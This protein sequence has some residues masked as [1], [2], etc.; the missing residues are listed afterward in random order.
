MSSIRQI[1]EGP[2]VVEYDGFLYYTEG[3][4]T[5]APDLKLREMNSSYFGPGDQRVT[6]KMFAVEF[7]PVGMMDDNKDKYYPYTIADLGKLIAPSTDKAVIIWAASGQKIT[8]PAGV[9]T[10]S[11]QLLFGVDQGPMGSMTI[12]CL[13]DITKA[14]AAADAHYKIETAALETHTLDWDKAP[15]PAYKLTLSTAGDIDGLTGFTFD[16]GATFTPRSCNRYGTVNYKLSALAPVITFAPAYQSESAMFNLLNIQGAGAAKLGG[17]HKLGQ[18]LTLL[19]AEA[20]AKGIQIDYPDCVI[21]S[22][23][24][25]FSRDDPRHGDYAII[26]AHVTGSS[27]YNITFPSWAAP[28]P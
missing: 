10:A 1:I 3:N 16:V 2:A 19:P 28:A 23:S 6:D 4:I 20:G 9:I 12:S 21:K 15:T 24:M 17:S 13:G 14:D 7:T 8:L 26:P 18:S 11:P 25:I 27:L 22:G 5:I